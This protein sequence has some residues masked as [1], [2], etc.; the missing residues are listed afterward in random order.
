MQNF[1]FV[2]QTVDYPSQSRV[3]SRTSFTFTLLDKI[4]R[5]FEG[6]FPSPVNENKGTCQFITLI[7][8]YFY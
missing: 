6:L 1:P 5:L 3:E 4:N 8:Q 2:F 7:A